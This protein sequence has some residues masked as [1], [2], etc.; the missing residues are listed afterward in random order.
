MKLVTEISLD[1]L[2]AQV[3]STEAV[4]FI[5]EILVWQDDRRLEKE[6]LEYLRGSDEED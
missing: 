3:P 1:D 4:Q 2:A 5:K 6:L